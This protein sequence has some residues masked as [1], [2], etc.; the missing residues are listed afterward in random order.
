[1]QGTQI[2]LLF[3]QCPRLEQLKALDR[4]VESDD[5]AEGEEPFMHRQ[6]LCPAGAMIHDLWLR[7]V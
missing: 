1:M 5:D 3:E 7:A 6:F 4:Q 2:S